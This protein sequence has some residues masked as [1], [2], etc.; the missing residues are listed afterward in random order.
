MLEHSNCNTS[1]LTFSKRRECLADGD[2]PGSLPSLNSGDYGRKIENS[3]IN[4]GDIG[5]SM[6]P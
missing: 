1:N 5:S 3:R 4:L 6:P 2:G